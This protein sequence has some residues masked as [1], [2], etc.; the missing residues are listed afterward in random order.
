MITTLAITA[1]QWLSTAQRK[2]T[3]METRSAISRE[4][5]KFAEYRSNIASFRDPIPCVNDFCLFSCPCVCD[6]CQYRSQILS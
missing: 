3:P 1:L 5:S 4:Q 6:N 2:A